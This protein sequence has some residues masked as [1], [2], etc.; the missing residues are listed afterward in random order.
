MK[1]DI[2]KE[3]PITS[4]SRKVELFPYFVHDNVEN[5]T[6]G[7]LFLTKDQADMLNKIMARN[8]ANHQRYAFLIGWE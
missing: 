7:N 8:G 3:I 6:V 1:G 4:F 2:R 5:K